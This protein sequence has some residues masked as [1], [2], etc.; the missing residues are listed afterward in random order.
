MPVLDPCQ[1]PLR[2]SNFA[3]FL[4]EL[5]QLGLRNAFSRSTGEQGWLSS[6]GS[7]PTP[8]FRHCCVDGAAGT[9]WG[10]P[11][12]RRIGVRKQEVAALSA[13]FV[14]E[15]L[16]KEELDREAEVGRRRRK[17]ILSIS[18]AGEEGRDLGDGSDSDSAAPK[19]VEHRLVSGERV[20]QI[21]K[22]GTRANEKLKSF[23]PVLLLVR[24]SERA[25][26]AI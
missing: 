3:P 21:S 22:A 8:R 9:K 10:K 6:A 26:F 2:D 18:A 5:A 20:L 24:V 15:E 23:S 4:V 14:D 1:F 19:L 7:A 11:K 25:G 12:L 17:R 13:S 16:E